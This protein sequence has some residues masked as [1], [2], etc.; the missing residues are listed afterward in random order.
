MTA[1][2]GV[3]RTHRFANELQRA[4][5]QL[6]FNQQDILVHVL[7]FCPVFDSQFIESSHYRAVDVQIKESKACIHSFLNDL[8]H[9]DRLNHTRAME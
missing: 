4:K 6:Q 5:A 7:R 3:T 1:F 2:S 9:I 8:A